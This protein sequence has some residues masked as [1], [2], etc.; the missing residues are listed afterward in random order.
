MSNEIS[1]VTHPLRICWENLMRKTCVPNFSSISSVVLEIWIP[2]SFWA[3]FFSSAQF[4]QQA[5]ISAINCVLLKLL[6]WKLVP[7]HFLRWGIQKTYTIPCCDITYGISKF[8][9]CVVEFTWNDPWIK[10][11][12]SSKTLLSSLSRCSLSSL[13]FSSCSAFILASSEIELLLKLK[14]VPIFNFI[15]LLIVVLQNVNILNNKE[16]YQLKYKI[17]WN[18]WLEKRYTL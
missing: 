12:C 9:F 17:E 2:G 18:L 1:H 6:N 4:G 5:L 10:L 13:S 16:G 15:Y 8:L 7:D 3:L 14:T 11:T